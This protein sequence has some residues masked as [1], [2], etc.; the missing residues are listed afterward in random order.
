M[1]NMFDKILSLII[2]L[3]IIFILFYLF[4]ITKD[5]NDIWDMLIEMQNIIKYLTSQSFISQRKENMITV[6]DVETTYQKNQNNGFDPSPFHPDI[7]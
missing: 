4:F 2:A 3:A 6:I 1:Y 5:L 7:I